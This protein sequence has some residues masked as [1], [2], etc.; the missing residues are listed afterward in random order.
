MRKMLIATGPSEQPLRVMLPF[1]DTAS[2]IEPRGHHARELSRHRSARP[3]RA[4]KAILR[5]L[6]A[7]L[8]VLTPRDPYNPVDETRREMLQSSSTRPRLHLVPDCG[9]ALEGAS[10]AHRVPSRF[11]HGSM[12]P[13]HHLRHLRGRRRRP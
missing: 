4:M 1:G 13:R 6:R 9:S 2:A 7:V 10:P 12:T 3:S 11:L 8:M 5:G